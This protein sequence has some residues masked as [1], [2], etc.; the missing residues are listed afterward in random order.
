MT[1]VEEGSEKVEGEQIEGEHDE[2]VFVDTFCL[3][4]RASMSLESRMILF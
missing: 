3:L 2:S 1:K 4:I